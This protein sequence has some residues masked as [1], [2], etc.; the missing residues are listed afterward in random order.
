M[1]MPTAKKTPPSKKNTGLIRIIAGY[2]R[3]RRLPVLV[4][5]GLRPTTDRMKE[6]LFNWLMHDTTDANVLDMFAGSG[7]LGIEALSRYAKSAVFVEKDKRVCEQL[8]QNLIT[9]KETKKSTVICDSALASRMIFTQSYDLVFIDPPYHKGLAQPS[10][11]LLHLHQSLTKGAKVYVETEAALSLDLSHYE[12]LKH[13]SNTTSHLL[14]LT[15][16][17]LFF[18]RSTSAANN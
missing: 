1:P 18:E 7:S 10:L 12:V 3:A 14:L 11:D 16:N 9:L 15:P 2:H 13:K 8:T 17:S 6:T 5:E 4:S